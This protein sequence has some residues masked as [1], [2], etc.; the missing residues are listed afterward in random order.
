[1]KFII[2]LLIASIM[3]VG[4]LGGYGGDYGSSYGEMKHER[5]D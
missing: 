4:V 5:P 3:S 2:T 1:M